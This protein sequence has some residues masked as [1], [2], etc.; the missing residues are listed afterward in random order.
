MLESKYQA[1][2]IFRIKQRFPDCIVLKND[3]TYIQGIPD[4]LVMY[5]E[6]W[7]ALEVKNRINASHQPNQDYYISKMGDMGFAEFICPETEEEVLDRLALYF[8]QT[9][10]RTNGIS[11]TP[12]LA[13]RNSRISRSV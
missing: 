6:L 10:E 12:G 7:A 3:A 8:A 9:E 1:A 13:K 11:Q 4:L 5:N 2:L